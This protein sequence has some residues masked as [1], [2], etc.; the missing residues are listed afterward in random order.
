MNAKEAQEM[1]A[2][3]R[4]HPTLIAQ[5]VPSPFTLPFDATIQ[6]IIRSGTLG[7]IVTIRV[8]AITG[9]FPDPQGAPLTWRQDRKYSGLNVLSMGIMYEALA[10][11]VGGATKVVAM[12]KTVTKLR[13]NAETSSLVGVTIPDHVDIIAEMACGAQAHMVFSAVCG[14][15]IGPVHEFWLHGTKGTLRLDLDDGKLQMAVA[16]EGEEL[17][18]VN[19]ERERRAGWRVEK[20]FVNAIR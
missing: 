15:D 1:L 11:W 13:T 9:K 7:D 8:K 18:D 5:I 10:R 17:K 16:E 2:I 12:T 6:D 19:I 20:E 4:L 3:S 14:G